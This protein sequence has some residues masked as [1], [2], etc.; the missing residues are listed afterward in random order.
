MFQRVGAAAYK[1][2][3]THIRLLCEALGQPQNHYKTLHVAGTNGKG[4]TCHMLASVLQEA[5]YRTGLTTSPHLVDFRERIRVNGDL[6]PEDKVA[7]FVTLIQPVVAQIEPS[8]FEVAIAMAFWY[9]REAQVDVA[10]VET[11]MGGRLDSTNIIRPEVSVI[12]NIGLDH[13]EFLGSTLQLIAT[14]K[15][16]I[17]KPGVPV[18]VGRFQ[19]ET[20]QVFQETARHTQSPVVEAWRHFSAEFE[21]DAIV[22]RHHG[23]MWVRAQCVLPG[24]YQLENYATVAA[25]IEVL[26]GKG[27][28]IPNRAVERGLAGVRTNTGLSGR[29]QVLNVRPAIILDTGHNPDGYRHVAE[30]FNAFPARRKWA[31]LGFTREKQPEELISL[32]EPSTQ[33][34]L[35]PMSV[36]RSRSFA[37][38]LQGVSRK[39]LLKGRVLQLL[40][41]AGSAAKL[42]KHT[43]SD[44]D[45]VLV[46]GSTFMVADF[47]RT[48]A[49]ILGIPVETMGVEPTTSTMP[50]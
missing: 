44:E 33:V 5:G 26:R 30:Q 48:G 2:D 17:I 28:S 24:R 9:F 47:L 34:L 10:V 16:G 50:L 22:I 1:K 6:I 46:G 37:E 41:S 42:L 31:V 21:Q 35:A 20:A 19:P 11:G 23:V 18:V 3:L 45:A 36:P 4:S 25:T 29:W 43:L 38:L 8:F 32:L 7:E 39:N 12:T 14:E 15:A 49:P 27:W 13:T 40:S